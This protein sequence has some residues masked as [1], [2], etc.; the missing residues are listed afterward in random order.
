LL[1]VG[2][3]AGAATSIASTV[4]H[5]ITITRSSLQEIVEKVP[6]SGAPCVCMEASFPHLVGWYSSLLL[7]SRNTER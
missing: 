7:L 6:T 5:S 3:A 1:R 2:P 4:R